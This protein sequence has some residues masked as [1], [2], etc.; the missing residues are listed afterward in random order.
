MLNGWA[1]GALYATSQERT[2]AL[3][4]WLY[5][6]TITADTAPSATSAYSQPTRLLLPTKS[7][8]D[9]APAC[10]TVRQRSP[11]SVRGNPKRDRMLGSRNCV[12]AAIRSPSRVSTTNPVAWAIGAC[13]SVR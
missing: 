1:Y 13:G 7:P 3:D 5:H 10:L 8:L 11:R 4:G 6:Y 12:S 2:A 9:G